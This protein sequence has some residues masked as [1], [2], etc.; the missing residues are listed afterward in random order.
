MVSVV[1]LPKMAVP[2]HQRVCRLIQRDLVHSNYDI[3]T[4]CLL[5]AG[6]VLA[7]SNYQL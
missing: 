6:S 4:K 1:L 2:K 3:Y 7:E 5:T